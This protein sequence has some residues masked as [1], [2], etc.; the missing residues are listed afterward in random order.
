MTLAMIAAGLWLMLDPA[1]TVGA[2]S[3]WSATV[4]RSGRSRCRDGAA[5]GAR[6]AHSAQQS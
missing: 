5:G 6:D 2:L 1:G 3:A 4:R